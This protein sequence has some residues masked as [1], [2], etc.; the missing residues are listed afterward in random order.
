MTISGIGFARSSSTPRAVAALACLVL[1]AAVGCSGPGSAPAFGLYVAEATN[2]HT[3]V[4]IDPAT[5]SDRG[6]GTPLVLG[7]SAWGWSFSGDGSTAV[8][9]VYPEGADRGLLTKPTVV[10]RD[11]R[12]GAERARLQSPAHGTGQLSRDGSRLLIQHRRAGPGWELHDWHLLDAGDGRVLG[13]GQAEGPSAQTWP[14]PE[15]RQLY[16]VLTPAYGLDRRGPGPVQIAAYDLETGAEVG[17]LELPGVL[18]GWWPGD[19]VIREERVTAYLTP[20]A[21]LSPD[22]RRIAVVDAEADRVTLIDAH[23]LAI[24]RTIPA[25][26]TRRPLGLA[27]RAAALGL[28]QVR[29]GRRS[30][31]RLRSGRPPSLRLGLRKHGRRRRRTRRPRPRTNGRRPGAW[32]HPRH[33][34]RR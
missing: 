15:L 34:P 10:I 30:R 6:G 7:S 13:S 9:V 16:R 29:R 8:G 23:A 11:A 18:G 24:E 31:G 25:A 20:G 21:A 5:L 28:R 19:R 26:R 17:R 32:H 1:L 4:P 2:G 33:G 14:D 12:T 3:L 22:G 27:S